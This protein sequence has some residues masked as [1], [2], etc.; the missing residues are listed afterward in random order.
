MTQKCRIWNKLHSMKTRLVVFLIWLLCISLQ[1]QVLQSPGSGIPGKV[2]ASFARGNDV[3]VLFQNSNGKYTAA[4]WQNNEWDFYDGLT[5]PNTGTV[6]ED[7]YNFTSIAIFK[8]TLY[9]GGYLDNFQA[10]DNFIDHL[11]KWDGGKWISINDVVKSKNFGI[12]ALDVFENKL[13]VAGKFS[14]VIGIVNVEN[15]AGFDGLNWKFIGTDNANQG[16]NGKIN[17]LTVIGDRLYIC[18]NFTQFAGSA[19]GNIAYY[20]SFNGNW[21]GIGSP[22]NAE[23]FQMASF[24]VGTKSY[25]AAF[26][27]NAG[28]NEVQVFDGTNWSA[29]KLDSFATAEINSIAGIDGYLLLGG[30]FINNSNGTSLLRYDVETGFS[31]TGNRVIDTFYLQQNE[32]AAFAWGNFKE[33]NSGIA[34]FAQIIPGFGQVYGTLYNDFNQNC[35]F[36]NTEK[37]LPNVVVKFT[38]VDNG[39]I[40]MLFTKDDGSFNLALPEGNYKVAINNTRHWQYSCG[41][42]SNIWIKSG[43]YSQLNLGQFKFSQI[44]DV[45]IQVVPAG[46][47][48]A[49]PGNKV[50]ML[51]LV[52][53]LGSS[54]IN[55]A[56]VY[57]KHP[58]NCS[59][60]SSEPATANYAN[61]EATYSLVHL[62]PDET[63]SYYIELQLPADAK[64]LESFKMNAYLGTALDGQDNY[65]QDNKDSFVFKSD[66]Y[67][68]PSSVYKISEV[69]NSVDMNVKEHKYTIGFENLSTETVN[70]V[71]VTDTV[72]NKSNFDGGS[73][74]E[75]SKGHK[76]NFY[77][78]NNTINIYKMEF[79]NVGLTSKEA[80]PTKS[81]GFITFS[82]KYSDRFNNNDSIP[83][84][85]YANFDNKWQGKSQTVWIKTFDPLSVN[86]YSTFNGK[87][88]PVPVKNNLN[89]AF[90]NSV[91]GNIE[92]Y[93]ITGA[94]L[95][96]QLIQNNN[97]AS[98]DVSGF[99]KGI[100]IVNTPAGNTKFI[101]Q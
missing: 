83:N 29:I 6:S 46:Q 10:S 32:N 49:K 88:F 56:T 5:K 70:N 12:T 38:R 93:S 14:S 99:A 75:I 53:N 40:F 96:S 89:I 30:K 54:E 19:T 59:N 1:A 51:L 35:N 11:R 18:G 81:F 68:V 78:S 21:G 23:A 66:L 77:Y 62:M 90:K 44:N 52:K 50:R 2:V 85:G 42:L 13:I 74:Y 28:K 7:R 91:S 48:A 101:V 87:L 97:A 26:G 100:Y 82:I 92:I 73:V 22:F 34:N 79:K 20:T 65:R 36:E 63:V 64:Q 16:T 58:D 69:G 31:F 61:N 67:Y 37:T 94:K 71:M 39:Q 15:I 45:S 84:T 8:D 57:L 4:R 17:K 55:G 9:V 86:N 24:S 33:Q 76:V 95:Y 27:V 41:I 43:K 80:N 47:L 98:I 72:V 60:F 3:A 25:K